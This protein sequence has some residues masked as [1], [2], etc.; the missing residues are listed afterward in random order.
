MTRS[1][2]YS[3]L[4]LRARPSGIDNREITFL[5]A[6]AGL[7]RATVFGGAK[8]KLRAHTEPYHQGTL[9]IYQDPAKDFRKVSDFDVRFWRPG[10]REGYERTM[11]AVSVA[12]T[13]LESCGGGGEWAASLALADRTLNALDQADCGTCRQIAV[14]FFWHWAEALGQRPGLRRC[15]SCAC[16]ADGDGVLWYSRLQGAFLCAPCAARSQEPRPN[17]LSLGPGARRW[18]AAV[19]G[20]DPALLSRYTLDKTAMEEAEALSTALIAGILGK[21][22]ASWNY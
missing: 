8:S 21:R 11:T 20:L 12:E 15:A 9:W 2:T 13:I 10:I 17:F 6:E 4:V 5:T 16:E 1:F 22:L 7:I 19:E 18:L 14:S 3:A